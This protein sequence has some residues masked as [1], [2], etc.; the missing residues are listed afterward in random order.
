[1]SGRHIANAPTPR[2]R[3]PLLAA[4]V[5]LLVLALAGAGSVAFARGSFSFAP[6]LGGCRSS[7]SFE[8]VTGPGIAP[9]LGQLAN[10]YADDHH[11]IGNRCVE[12]KIVAQDPAAVVGRLAQDA[13][14][15]DPVPLPDVW[16]PNSSAWANLLDG[17]RPG[18]LPTERPKV[19]TSP[20]VL[21][22]PRPMA[23]ALGWPVVPSGWSDMLKALR[24]P[25]GWG[26]FGHPTWGPILLGKTNPTVSTAGLHSGIATFAALAGG[27][28]PTVQTVTNQT[29]VGTFLA[30][31]RAPGPYAETTE[32]FL[33]GLQQADDQ[34][35]ALRYLSALPAEEK[36]VFD[37]NQGNPD[38]HPESLGKHPKP[39]I[40]LVAV[41]P[42]EGTMESDHP[43]LVLQGPWVTPAKRSAAADFLRYLRSGPAQAQFMAAGFR[44]FEGTAGPAATPANGLIADQPHRIMPFPAPKVTQIIAGTW[45][46]VRKRG[47]VL[48]VLDVSGSMKANVPGTTATKLDLVKVAALS[49]QPL[50]SD[51]DNVGLWTFNAG[52]N[53]G[54]DFR[55]AVPLGRMGD[56]V[57]GRPARLLHRTA[58][59]AMVA[60]GGTA[61]YDTTLAAVRYVQKKWVPGRI[62]TVVV[63]TDGIDTKQGGLSESALL[64][65][66]RAVATSAQ[67]VRIIT[68]AY[69]AD[70]DQAVLQRIAAATHGA[71]YV[72]ADP[73]EIQRIFIAAIANF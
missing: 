10:A 4:L 65:A 53:G 21:A 23:E 46:K 51:E 35:V 11:K 9:L 28:A 63:M 25:A 61:L 29:I 52:T 16:L 71:A 58:L 50:F 70:A 20:L 2:S 24:N 69:G 18:L 5:G 17:V 67:P 47:N 14:P 40:P 36:A 7:L 22:M 37:Y 6:L 39:K 12:P 27:G 42:K 49:S 57:G 19:V 38:G 48:A 26:Q 1:V 66:L 68:I 32:A 15:G 62:N 55:V 33:A 44:S 73:K 41:Y 8:V 72:S 60:G 43:W 45:E 31:E 64:T 13:Q 54:P 59:K 30:V 56:L 3:R 34:N